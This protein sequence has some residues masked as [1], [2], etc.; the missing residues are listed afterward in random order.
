MTNIQQLISD[1]RTIELAAEMG[2]LGGVLTAL[3][4]GM[5]AQELAGCETEA[6]AINRA[7]SFI[8]WVQ[9]QGQKAN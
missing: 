5:I 6:D 1:L 8:A 4:A 7:E 9:L 3:E 2:I